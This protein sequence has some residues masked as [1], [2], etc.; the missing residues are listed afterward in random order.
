MY[1]QNMK[2]I[3]LS[4]PEGI[5]SMVDE[6]AKQDFTTRSDII[7]SAVLW[8]LRPQGRDL[9][10]IDPEVVVE[11]MQM[12]KALKSSRQLKRKLSSRESEA[13]SSP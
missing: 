6:A 8:Y 9:R 5:L 1:G 12:R 2:R 10:D 11:I 3:N 7:R 4:I 13:E